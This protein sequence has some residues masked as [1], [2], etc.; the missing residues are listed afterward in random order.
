MW[1]VLPAISAGRISMRAAWTASCSIPTTIWISATSIAELGS[2]LS[3]RL[4]RSFPP[5]A[6]Q[7]SI[8]KESKR[9]KAIASHFRLHHLRLSVCGRVLLPGFHLGYRGHGA[10]RR[11]V[12][13][14]SL[15]AGHHLR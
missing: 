10:D 14:Y 12:S 15:L 9:D 3:S 13:R 2:P 7:V 1:S 6:G 11:A 4:L 5:D 8:T